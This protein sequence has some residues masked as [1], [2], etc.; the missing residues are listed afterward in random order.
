MYNNNLTLTFE[1]QCQIINGFS[2]ISNSLIK[3]YVKFTVKTRKILLAS[4][5]SLNWKFYS[6]SSFFLTLPTK[7]A[8]IPSQSTNVKLI[9]N[10]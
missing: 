7:M 5:K 9:I 4:H 6:Y 10:N 3:F 2:I 1:F 8:F